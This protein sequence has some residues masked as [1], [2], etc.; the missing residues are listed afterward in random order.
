MRTGR[1]ARPAAVS[2]I[3]V[4]PS[5]AR[6]EHP[7]PD[8]VG[9]ALADVLTREM[10]DRLDAFERAVD[11]ASLGIPLNLGRAGWRPTDE[12]EQVVPGPVERGREGRP[13]QARTIR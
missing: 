8:V 3:R 5:D 6:V 1:L 9:P 10:D 11:R 4:V 13:D 7:A 12:V 2:A